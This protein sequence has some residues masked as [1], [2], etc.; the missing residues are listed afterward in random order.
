MSLDHINAFFE[1]VGSVLVWF[2]VKQLIQDKKVMGISL[3][4]SVFY[5]VWSLWSVYYYPNLDQWFSFG[6]GVLLAIGNIFWCSM[7]IYY[8]FRN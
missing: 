5:C 7:A 3:S 6:G 2:N 1:I 8:R 4:V